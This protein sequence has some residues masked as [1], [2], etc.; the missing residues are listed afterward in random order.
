MSQPLPT[1]QRHNT[2]R[3][4]WAVPRMAGKCELPMNSGTPSLSYQ[5]LALFN[6][7]QRAPVTIGITVTFKAP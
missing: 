2:L 4:R 1:A 6:M 7:P 3:N 5:V